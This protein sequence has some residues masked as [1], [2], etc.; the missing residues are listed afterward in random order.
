MMLQHSLLVELF[1][2]PLTAYKDRSPSSG[3]QK[4]VT[5][6]VGGEG[7]PSWGRG[8]PSIFIDEA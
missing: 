1:S 5:G 7:H 6:H 4:M 3:N 8:H 2:S